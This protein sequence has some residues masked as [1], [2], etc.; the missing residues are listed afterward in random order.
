MSLIQRLAAP[1]LTL[2]MALVLGLCGLARA[3]N[4]TPLSEADLTKLVELQV[5]DDAVIA[6][7][8]RSGVAFPI[9]AA[10]LERLRKA[11]A[12]ESILAVV[13][14]AGQ[15]AN[16]LTYQGILKH[17]QQGTNE[18]EILTRL[19]ES[20]TTFGLDRG[21]IGALVRAGASPRLIEALQQ[22]GNPVSSGSDIS[23]FVVILDCS[24]SMTG[25]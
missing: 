1:A 17:V 19:R 22:L 14:E 7:V 8:G 25:L 24:G 9:D 15:P 18:D 21:Q 12:S 6:R 3:Q 16:A 2:A 20:P 10:A 13:R 4:V 23:D 5:G 11:G